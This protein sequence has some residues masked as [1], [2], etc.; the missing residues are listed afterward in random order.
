MDKL[1]L[2]EIRHRVSQMASFARN[3][4][5]TTD[6]L[7]WSEPEEISDFIY[8]VELLAELLET[9]ERDLER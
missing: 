1:E 6:G 3:L 4:V 2:N 5:N 9:T 8:L 7:D